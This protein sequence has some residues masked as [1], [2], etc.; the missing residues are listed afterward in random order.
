M[1]KIVWIM[2][3]AGLSTSMLSP[4]LCD[5]QAPQRSAPAQA[6]SPASVQPQAAPEIKTDPK[7]PVKLAPPTPIAVKKAELGDDNAWNPD[8]DKLIEQ[9]LPADLL[10]NK[11]ER[12]VKSLCPGFKKLSETDKRAFWAYFFQAL[13]GAEAGLKPTADV[14]HTEPEVAV[15][16]TVTHRIVR[17]EGLLQ[18]TYMDGPRYGCAFDWNADKDL[19]EH[20][21]AKTILQPGNNLLCGLRILDNQMLVRHKPLLSQ[22]SYWVTLRPGTMSFNVFIKQ[23]A[24]EPA[25]CGVVRRRRRRGKDT[26]PLS[27]ADNDRSGARS[28]SQAGD[29]P[30]ASKPGARPTS[31]GSVASDAAGAGTAAAAH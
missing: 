18:L 10:S 22:S 9:S 30:A 1:C 2:A 28:G 20:D 19:P 29:Q 27:E 6:A 21:P 16:D 5:G 31:T 23:M 3:C 4:R 13:A 26:Q 11:R 24:N 7:A 25:A 8:W 17:Q 15:T 12:A 14:R